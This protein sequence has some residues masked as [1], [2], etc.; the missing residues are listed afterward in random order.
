MRACVQLMQ[1]AQGALGGGDKKGGGKDQS[2][3][4]PSCLAWYLTF[5]R[6]Q[7]CRW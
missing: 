3:R 1:Q 4:G 2:V 6:W 5:F 7:S